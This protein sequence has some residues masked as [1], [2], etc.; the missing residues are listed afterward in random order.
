MSTHDDVHGP[1][2]VARLVPARST[3]AANR[4]RAMAAELGTQWGATRLRR[5]QRNEVRRWLATNPPS[6]GR[7]TGARC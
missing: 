6:R 1:A 4:L 3:S 2:L 7:R 5:E